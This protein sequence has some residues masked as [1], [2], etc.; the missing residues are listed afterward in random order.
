MGRRIERARLGQEARRDE[1]LDEGMVESH[2]QPLFRC[3]ADRAVELGAESPRH[4]RRL[5][6]IEH[7]ALGHDRPALQGREPGREVRQRRVPRLR[8]ATCEP[9]LERAVHHEIRVAAD[10]RGEMEVVLERE[11]EVA[12]RRVGVARLFHGP[13]RHHMDQPLG[14]VPLGFFEHPLQR[15]RIDVGGHRVDQP[16]THE[17]RTECVEILVIR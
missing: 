13:Q 4:E 7:V 8:G 9:G 15:P 17:E 14:A 5:L 11:R 2:V 6:E 16:H 1:P 12:Q 10:R 3:A